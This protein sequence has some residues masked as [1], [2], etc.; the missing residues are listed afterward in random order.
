MQRHQATHTF[1][2]NSQCAHLEVKQDPG[3][4]S[5]IYS[6]AS[7][8]TPALDYCPC[9]KTAL[10][11]CCPHCL[12][13]FQSKPLNFCSL[14]GGSL[15][16]LAVPHEE[17]LFCQICNRRMY[18]KIQ[19]DGPLL[20]SDGCIN[21]FIKNNI[22]ICDQCGKRFNFQENISECFINLSTKDGESGDLDFC[23]RICM[24]KYMASQVT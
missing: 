8:G 3:S 18:G 23:S 12:H 4:Y 13:V 11:S 20:C 15:K 22:R 19:A 14:C 2:S 7:D 9:C 6:V 21:L 1:C 24:E 10:S 16:V 5:C 17:K